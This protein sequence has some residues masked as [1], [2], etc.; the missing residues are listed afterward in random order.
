[1]FIEQ[2]N[3]LVGCSEWEDIVLLKVKMS[4]YVVTFTFK[5]LSKNAFMHTL[6]E[7]YS[8][9]KLSYFEARI[10]HWCCPFQLLHSGM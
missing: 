10:T 9:V 8:I 6:I 3:F 2:D 7:F 1:M 5:I 4:A